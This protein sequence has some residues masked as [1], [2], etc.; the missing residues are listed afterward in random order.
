MNNAEL[1]QHLFNARCGDELDS[2]VVVAEDFVSVGALS[3]SELEKVFAVVLEKLRLA[4]DR[5]A[6]LHLLSS[7]S[8]SLGSLAGQTLEELISL[9]GEFNA[10]EMLHLVNILSNSDNAKYISF[11]EKLV[12]LGGDEV[13]PAA[14]D[15]IA[16]LYNRIG[17]KG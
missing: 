10:G 12:Q 13:S 4:K 16:E 3:R 7:C 5:E 6:A 15:A 17:E 8:V 9:S 1:V 11:L 14:E 2:A